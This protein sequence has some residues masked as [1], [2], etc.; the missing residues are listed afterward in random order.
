MIAAVP[1]EVN[2][3][4]PITAELSQYVA[5][6]LQ[7]VTVPRVTGE[8]LDTAA[9]KVTAVPEAT[10]EDDSVSVVVVT[11]LTVSVPLTNANE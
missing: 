5:V 2:C 9:V 1:A 11:A 7:K 10:E 8:P 6:A 4:V 3:A